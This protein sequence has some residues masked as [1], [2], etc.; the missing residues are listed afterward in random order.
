MIVIG[1]RLSADILSSRVT[2]YG[3]Q[4]LILVITETRH[5]VH[6]NPFN[7]Y[8]ILKVSLPSVCGILKRLISFGFILHKRPI[9][10]RLVFYCFINIYCIHVK[11]IIFFL[12]LMYIPSFLIVYYLHILIYTSDTSLWP[13]T[14]PF[15]SGLG[16]CFW[17]SVSRF[18][19]TWIGICVSFQ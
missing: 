1:P 3:A 10:N 9:W 19:N 18:E 5:W 6:S 17:I 16:Q 12:C 8:R 7:F 15:I 2:S 14:F 4:G 13:F 11:L